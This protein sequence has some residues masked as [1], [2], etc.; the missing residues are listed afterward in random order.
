LIL[1]EATSALD[2]ETE[3]L[4]LKKL[5]YLFRY[6]IIIMVSH[7]K[8]SLRFCNKIYEIKNQK[9]KSIN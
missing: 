8:K 3:K 2:F 5:K 1:D 7:S 4:I 6:K 9:I